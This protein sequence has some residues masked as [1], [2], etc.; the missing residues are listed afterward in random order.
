MEETLDNEKNLRL[1]YITSVEVQRTSPADVED[2]KADLS[3]EFSLA[4]ISDT[5]QVRKF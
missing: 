2:I 5:S 4:S 1:S 3:S